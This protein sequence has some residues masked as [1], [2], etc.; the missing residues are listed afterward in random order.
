[1]GNLSLFRPKRGRTI[2]YGTFPAKPMP[3]LW[4]QR[5]RSRLG[6]VAVLVLGLLA[7][8]YDQA[9]SLL[10]EPETGRFH[11]IDGDSLRMDGREFRLKGIDAPELNQT[12][13]TASGRTYTCGRDAHAALTRLVAG[14][15]LTCSSEGTDRYGRTLTYCAS[16]EIDIN[17]EMVN[18]GWAI[19]Y[20]GFDISYW[21]I[22]N[23]ARQDRRGIW[24]GRFEYPEVW[25]N[26]HKSSHVRS[27]LAPD[28]IG[29]D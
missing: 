20:R 8:L 27:G 15:K 19:A 24:Q 21:L 18:R 26:R 13:G 14:S 3:R 5:L 22:E 1:M 25:R 16:G 17:G 28:E 4:Y 9:T 12:C 6:F 29:G 10:V 11:A 7:A 23:A 2:S